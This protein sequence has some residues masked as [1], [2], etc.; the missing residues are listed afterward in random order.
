[1]NTLARAAAVVAIAVVAIGTTALLVAPRTGVSGPS[2]SSQPS[3][4]PA[5]S[6]P[7]LAAS[8]AP[9][10]TLNATFTSPSYGYRIRFPAGWKV[11]AGHAPWPFGTTLGPGDSIT[12]SIVTP[13]GP[14][15]MRISIVSIALPSGTTMDEFRGFASPYSSPFNSDPC[16][17]VAPLREPVLISYRKNASASPERVAAVVSINGCA[18]L[19]ELGGNVYDVEVIAGGR[20]YEFILDGWLTPADAMAWLGAITL[21][22]TTA[23]TG[24]EAPA[25]SASH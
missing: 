21:E 19:A 1:M 23:P 17:P 8:S 12:D 13:S 9:L 10:P 3:A 5:S 16:T 25:P 7:S 6:L 15:R 2:P 11:T 4:S 18:A 24:S 14:H 22:P 20:G